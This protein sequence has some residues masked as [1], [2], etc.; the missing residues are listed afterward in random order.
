MCWFKHLSCLWS[1]RIHSSSPGFLTLCHQAGLLLLGGPPPQASKN[2]WDKE[3]R[4]EPFLEKVGSPPHPATFALWLQMAENCLKKKKW[5][6]GL[7]NTKSRDGPTLAMAGF[8][9]QTCHKGMFLVI[10]Q[11]AFLYVGFSLGFM[12]RKLAAKVVPWIPLRF[13]YL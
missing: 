11:F 7:C 12:C 5:M 4:M 3:Q 1:Q 10:S 13:L 2:L 9:A 8:R 6:C